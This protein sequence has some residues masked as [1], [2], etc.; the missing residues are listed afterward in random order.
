VKP[1]AFRYERPDTVDET[2]DLLANLGDEAKVLAGG[3]SLVPMM[4]FR[5]ARPE[6]IIDIGRVPGIDQIRVSD[7][8]VGIGARVRHQQL[9]RRPFDGPLQDLFLQAGRHIGH[10][11]IRLRGT[12]GGSI[13]H[14]DPVAEWCLVA[15]ALDAEVVVRSVRGERTISLA[16]LFE[17]SFTTTIADDELLTEVRV[18]LLAD[19]WSTGF[20]EFSR[21][22]GDF[23]VVAIATAVRVQNGLVTEAKV[24]AGGVAGTP[25]R[26]PA[27]EASLI[28]G[29]LD[30]VSI[31]TAGEIASSEVQPRADI[32]GS[33]MY[34]RELVAAMTRRALQ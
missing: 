1:A 10:L 2:V 12:F 7:G 21:R 24:A 30:A 13:A 23:A 26:L 33:S 22:T 4:N 25:I 31:S 34:R 3:Q 19:D 5:L 20:A 8:V 15:L 16:E 27:T 29:P 17:M 32:H 28:G 6:A 9:L 11:P 18:P 14:A